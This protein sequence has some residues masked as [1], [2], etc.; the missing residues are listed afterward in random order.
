MHV[1]EARLAAN[2]LNGLK[3]KG[4]T[5]EA[6][7]LNSRKN[8][9]K[10]GLTGEGVVVPEG[11]AEEIQ[12]RAEAL[13]AD[14]KPKS[15]AGLILITQM[16]TLS[17][18]AERAAEQELAQTSMRVRNAADA[19]DE[20]RIERANELFEGLADDPRNNL[21]KLKKMPEGVELLV[22][23]WTDLRHDLTAEPAAIWTAEQLEQAARMTGLKAQHAR[24]S[25]LGAL[26]RGFWGDFAALG[27]GEGAGLDEEFRR[28]WARAQ[29]L[30]R[31]DAEIADLEA[32]YE[33]LDFQT[34]ALDRLEAGQRALFD[35]SKPASLAR[36][37]ESEARNGFFKALKEFHRVEAEHEASVE[38]TP[39][40]PAP[41]LPEP[42]MGSFR[43]T[44]STL[45]REPS[46]PDFDDAR[47]EFLVSVTADNQSSMDRHTVKGLA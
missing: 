12:A 40:R 35:P 28:E 37:Y 47:G 33:T 16:A 36:R 11:D 43:E 17:V 8:S 20:E 18:R 32:H 5:T 19:F 38:A 39:S 29:L 2:R 45:R 10:H 42:K 27:E 3:G 23:A 26:S 7:R 9:L 15:P 46:R 41:T 25:R 14:M 34:I 6:G 31:I 22:D 30:E 21:R 44:T 13:T 24:G 4:P 1:S